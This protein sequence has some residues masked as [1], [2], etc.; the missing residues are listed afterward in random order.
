MCASLLFLVP[1]CSLRG[2]DLDKMV[3]KERD[4]D[5]FP[6]AFSVLFEFFMLFLLKCNLSKDFLRVSNFVSFYILLTIRN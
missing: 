3:E 5:S 2:H 1:D 4:K 6:C